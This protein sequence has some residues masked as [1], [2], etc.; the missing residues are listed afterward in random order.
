MMRCD[1]ARN[2]AA[3]A[4]GG[5]GR[6]PGSDR[7]R[8][9]S[10]PQRRSGAWSPPAARSPRKR[11]QPVGIAGQ[12]GRVVRVLVDAGSWVR[13]GQVLAIVDRSVQAQQAA[14]LAAQIEAAQGAC[15]ARPVRLRPRHRASGP[16]LHLQGRDRF[17]EGARATPPTRRCG[18]PRRSSARPARQIGQLNVVAPSCRPDPRRATSSS[19]R[20]SAPAPA[21]CS[22]SP[23]AAQMEMRA[24]LVA[25]GSRLRPRRHAGAGHA[26]RRRRRASPARSGRSRR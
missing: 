19:A 15:R 7:H 25:A 20:S 11:D 23:R 3:A 10:G 17:Q 22:A 18:S 2:A 6:G 1:A 5:G 13:A 4:A 24:Q 16:R 9:R 21:R 26:G 14:Q 12:G 8:G